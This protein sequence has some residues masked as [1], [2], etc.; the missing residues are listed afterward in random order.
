MRGASLLQLAGVARCYALVL[1]HN[2]FA[3]LV[4]NIK[5]GN[6]ATQTLTNV[7]HLG[8]TVHQT[9]IV[10]D[11]EIG[12]DG[13]VVQTNGLEQ[14]RDRHLAATV[15]TEIQQ[16]FWIELK[17]EPGATVGDNSG[18]EQQ[19]ARAVGLALVVFKKHARRAVQLGHDHTLG[20]VDD[21]RPL[22][23]HQRHFA[24][25]DL[26]LLH[27]F[28]HLVLGGRRLTVI[29]DQLHLGTYGRGI[30]Q[31][32]GLALTHVKCRFGQVVFEIFHLDKAVVRNDG[33]RSFECGL[34][35][36]GS[37][38]FGRH[39]GLQERGVGILLHLQQIG[40]FQHAVARAKVFTN[41]LA[42]SE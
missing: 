19:L 29:N 35:A 38:L 18:R 42:F 36:F 30:G 39:I 7:F 13:L 40:D 41:T 14:N 28:H 22:G 37:S 21:E 3:A 27:F 31:A 24:H 10:V 17:I 9:E 5:T 32:A 8:A 26:L 20:T 6:F 34:Q 25:V 12:K 15:N 11:E 1:G 33:E 2:D 23:R 4:R 16:V